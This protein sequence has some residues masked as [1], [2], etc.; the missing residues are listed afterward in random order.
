VT[1]R[2]WLA[3]SMA[4]MLFSCETFSAG[5]GDCCSAWQRS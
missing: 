2:L 1:T 5:S 3:L 4:A